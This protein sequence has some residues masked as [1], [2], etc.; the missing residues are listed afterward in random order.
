MP[1]F[2]DHLTLHTYRC[3]IGI[4]VYKLAVKQTEGYILLTVWPILFIMS[5]LKTNS[6]MKRQCYSLMIILGYIEY[7][8]LHQD[9]HLHKHQNYFIIRNSDNITA[10]VTVIAT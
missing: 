2:N 4:T 1:L 3:T 8:V 9:K 7:S 10:Y 5:S 6:A